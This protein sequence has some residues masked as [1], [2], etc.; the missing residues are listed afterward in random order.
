MSSRF[1]VVFE[2]V[3][4][5]TPSLVMQNLTYGDTKLYIWARFDTSK[6]YACFGRN[7]RAYCSQVLE[8]ISKKA[9]GIFF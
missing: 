8:D 1:W 4:G 2:D 7:N 3:Y 5:Q 6:A 9:S